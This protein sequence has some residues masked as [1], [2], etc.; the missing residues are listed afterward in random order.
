MFIFIITLY[1]KRDS[2]KW[3]SAERD[4]ANG[5]SAKRDSANG[6]S[7]KRDSAKRDSAK[8]DSTKQDSAKRDSAKRD[9]AKRDSAKWDSAK[10]EDTGTI[11]HDTLSAFSMLSASLEPPDFYRTLVVQVCAVEVWRF[12]TSYRLPSLLILVSNVSIY[13]FLECEQCSH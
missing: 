1:W 10:R 7:A 5:D 2:A 6:D 11:L 12:E 13:I 4:S 9:S 3:D 8:R